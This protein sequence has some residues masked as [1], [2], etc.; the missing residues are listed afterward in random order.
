MSALSTIRQTVAAPETEIKRWR[1][2]FDTNAKAE[3]NGQKLAI[4]QL[5]VSF[6]LI[7]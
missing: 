1:R 6:K 2:T 4:S 7:L 5:H 3:A